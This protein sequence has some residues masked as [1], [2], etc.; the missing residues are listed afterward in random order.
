LNPRNWTLRVRLTMLYGGLFFLAG[1]VLMAVTYLLVQ[2]SLPAVGTGTNKVLISKIDQRPVTL[3]P[4]VTED[5][6]AERNAYRTDIL[7]S[8]LLSGGLAL[9]LVGL[10][11][12]G[13]GWIV[14]ERVLRPLH[15]ITD[16]ARRIA[17]A[18][19]GASGLHER[20]ALTG[21]RD[22]I[23]ELA[24]TF[25]AM[26]ERLDRSFDGQR[27]FVSN[28]SHE[29]RT[30]LAINRALLEVA[31]TRPDASPDVRQLG[32]TLLAVNGRHERLID[33]LLTLAQ[34][35]HELVHRTPVDL[36]QIVEYVADETAHQARTAGVTVGLDTEPATV[37]G[38][39][40]LLERLVTNLLLNAVK[41]NIA[42]NG[43][44][45]A[46]TRRSN[47]VAELVVTNS[48]PAVPGYEAEAI[49]EPFRR[50]ANR[51]NGTSGVGLGLS[52]VR[53]VAR[54]HGGDTRAEPRRGGG[55]VVH[56][57]L[58]GQ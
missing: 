54:A 19:S 28:A 9:L 5:L 18:P 37:G 27:R 30:P 12:I 3:P 7:N 40:V 21:P 57:R 24:D 55:L 50:L 43:W 23:A 35:E 10:A 42:E 15:R 1:A 44:V 16:T 52:I 8:L 26:L 20:I 25:D 32:G 56:V 17:S 2:Q 22:E 4:Q 14:A 45:R 34:S 13:L 53:A 47:G 29:L 41:Y 6:I 38:D 33:G 11:A 49:F 58:P 39:P 36:A 48:G 51:R 46:S 31:V